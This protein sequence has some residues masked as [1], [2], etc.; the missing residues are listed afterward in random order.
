MA[1]ST[2]PLNE[3]PVPAGE[4]L[5]IT[6][7]T[8]ADLLRMAIEK[9]ANME[10]V[11][12]LA[13]LWER[14]ELNEARRAYVAAMTEFKKTAPAILKNKHVQFTAKGKDGR[15]VIVSYDYATLDHVCNIVIPLLAEHG[16]S[17]DWEIDQP[18]PDW[19]K[20]TC[21]LTHESGFTKQT[22]I[23]A[24]PDQTGAKNPVQA[25]GSTIFYLERY[26]LLARV[27]L[28]AKNQDSDGR[29]LEGVTP[30]NPEAAVKHI[31]AQCSQLTKA[32]TEDQLGKLFREF[33]STATAA[34]DESAQ[35][36]LIR[37]KESRFR[38]LLRGQSR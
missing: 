15:E 1:T 24:A 18:K 30:A 6:T 22:S 19:I 10:N 2:Q 16:F 28:V 25:I 23:Q 13:E 14:W 26:T 34:K 7:P 4:A 31:D 17:H 11:I 21:M 29:V 35:A 33:Y 36:Q 27:G 9:N 38:A 8:P 32:A 37:A 12:Q 20:V 5:T 3:I